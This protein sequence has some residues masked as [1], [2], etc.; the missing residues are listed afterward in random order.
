MT[1]KIN[2]LPLSELAKLEPWM[3]PPSRKKELDEYL[4]LQRKSEVEA[5]DKQYLSTQTIKPGQAVGD[6]GN[7]LR[8][9]QNSQKPQENND[10]IPKDHSIESRTL[11][12]LEA[13]IHQF[14]NQKSALELSVVAEE[15]ASLLSD[16]DFF[17]ALYKRDDKEHSWL[18]KWSKAIQEAMENE[19][20]VRIKKEIMRRKREEIEEEKCREQKIYEDW[21]KFLQ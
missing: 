9:D 15:A 3:V 19:K 8:D 20:D 5:N 13:Q 11:G 7:L 17:L 18:E 2:Q 4:R 16:I 6:D 10:L 1:D 21:L 14:F 12:S